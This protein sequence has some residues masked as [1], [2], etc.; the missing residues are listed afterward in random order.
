M[1]AHAD[2]VIVGAGHGGAQVAIALRPAMGS[3]SRMK[4]CG[5]VYETVRRWVLKF[6]P[7]SRADCLFNLQDVPS[8]R[9]RGFESGSLRRELR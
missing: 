7:L 3:T 5:A 8:E 2:V 9:D 4:R 6:G 1:S